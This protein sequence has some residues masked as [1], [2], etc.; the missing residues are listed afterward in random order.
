MH[1]QSGS[2]VWVIFEIIK[3]CMYRL[4]Y[5][6]YWKLNIQRF[7]KKVKWTIQE[8]GNAVKNLKKVPHIVQYEKSIKYKVFYISSL[9]VYTSIY[10]EKVKTD[11]KQKRKTHNIKYFI[12][13][14]LSVV[15]IYIV[16]LFIKWKKKPFKHVNNKYIFSFNEWAVPIN[17]NAQVLFY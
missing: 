13:L 14:N 9:E 15:L 12:M 6:C 5:A 16:Y 11:N 2:K 3:F 10:T 17:R 8:P 1:M 4:M 7:R